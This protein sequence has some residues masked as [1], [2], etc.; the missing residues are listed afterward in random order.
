[1][2]SL[3]TLK[4]EIEKERAVLDQMLMTKGMEEVIEQSRKL[5][6]MIEIYLGKVNQRKTG[7]ETITGKTEMEKAYQS[8]EYLT[9]MPFFLN[10]NFV[11]N[12]K[13]LVFFS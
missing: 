7:T 11:F 8:K 5:D 1:M 13:T 9:D 12:Q 2:R 3:E 6:Q 4:N 10:K